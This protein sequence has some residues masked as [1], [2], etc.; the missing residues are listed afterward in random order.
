M[1]LDALD[2]QYGFIKNFVTGVRKELTTH[3]KIAIL[4]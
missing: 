2:L 3:I 1:I 4:P